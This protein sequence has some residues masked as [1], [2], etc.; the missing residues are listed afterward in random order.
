MKKISQQ[1]QP[2]EAN[3]GKSSKCGKSRLACHH[4]Q[5]TWLHSMWKGAGEDSTFRGEEAVQSFIRL[6]ILPPIHPSTHDSFT[7]SSI[8][9]R[10]SSFAGSPSSRP[11][12]G[13][14]V[15]SLPPS[16]PLLTRE[17]HLPSAPYKRV[18]LRISHFSAAVI[19]TVTKET[20]R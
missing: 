15:H 12:T 16:C 14:T 5:N 4:V 6:V 17:L 7:L 18:Q 10:H 9:L 1:L 11:F 2:S 20:Y 13:P 3:N 19:N 8:Q